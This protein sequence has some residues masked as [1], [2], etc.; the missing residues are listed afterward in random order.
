MSLITR[1]FPIGLAAVVLVAPAA[2]AADSADEKWTEIETLMQGPKERP[3]SQEEAKEMMKKGF[4]EIDAKAEAFKKEFPKDARRW[5]LEA[6]T[7]Q[8]NR[9]RGFA[10]IPMKSDEE[11]SKLSKEVLAA[12]DAPKDVKGQISFFNVVSARQAANFAE[13]AEAHL[14]EYP[15]FPGNAQLKSQLEANAAQA[16]LKSKPLELKYTAVD[17]KE[18]NLEAMRGKVV[19]VD[20]WATWCGPCVA[21]IPHVLSAYEKFHPKGFEV[22]GISF[23]QDK[24]KLEKFTKDK[25]MTWPQYFD[26]KGWQNEFGQKFG[27]DSIPRMWLVNKKGMVVDFEGRENLAEKVEK[28]LAE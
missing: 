23:D 22:V 19:L 10:G 24:E 20:F 11:I 18:V 25:G 14:K 15:D 27:I 4:A 17:G 28:L 5:Q 7:I 16:A 21:E 1:S 2:F 26:G 9:A 8:S 12:A 3:K 6:F 13:L